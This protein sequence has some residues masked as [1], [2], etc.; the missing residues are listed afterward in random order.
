[1]PK[2][3]CTYCDSTCTIEPEEDVDIVFCPCCGEQYIEENDLEYDD[4]DDDF[5]YKD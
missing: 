5:K 1:M 2:F 3:E 4:E